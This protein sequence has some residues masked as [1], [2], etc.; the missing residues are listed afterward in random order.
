MDKYVF[1][2]HFTAFAANSQIQLVI[3]SGSK[4]V[5]KLGGMPKFASGQQGRGQGFD[6]TEHWDAG[7]CLGATGRGS[8]H[9]R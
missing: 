5:S 8:F 9:S 4:L 2:C 6:Y 1:V 7:N 3:L